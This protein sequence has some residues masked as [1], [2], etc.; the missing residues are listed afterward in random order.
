VKVG[1]EDIFKLTCGNQNLYE[2]G[3]DIGVRI[4]KFATSRSLIDRN[5]MFIQCS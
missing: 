5:A 4:V 3:N 2:T 1:R